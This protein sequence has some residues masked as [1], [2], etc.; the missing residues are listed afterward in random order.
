MQNIYAELTFVCPSY[1][2]AEAYSSQCRKAYK[3]G[4]NVQPGTHALDLPSYLGPLGGVPYLSA[5][6]QRAVMTMWGRFVTQENPSLPHAVAAGTGAHAAARWPA[7]SVAQPYQLNIDQ[8]GG[9]AA[10]GAMEVYS[11][12]DTIFFTEPGLRPGF[13][14]V[15]AYTWEHGRGVRCDFWRSQAAI[16]PA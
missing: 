14:L 13:S 9:T 5:D 3:Y 15:D 6:V 12:V 11:P 4:F 1:W 16:I 2:L 10:V 7:F 8:T